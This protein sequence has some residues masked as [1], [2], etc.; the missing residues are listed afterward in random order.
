MLPALLAPLAISLIP[1]AA[2]AI[3]NLFA[4]PKGGEAAVALAEVAQRVTGTDDPDQQ[5]DVIEANPD[6]RLALQKGLEQIMADHALAMA[7]EDTER[8]RIAAA[9]TADARAMATANT[10]SG[11]GNRMRDTVAV[12]TLII[13]CL[14]AAGS[15]AAVM[16][17]AD[18][19]VLT[20]TGTIMGAT[21]AGYRDVV[22][23]F[24]GSSAGS[25]SKERALSGLAQHGPTA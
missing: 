20:L 8:A 5:R 7:R 21:I 15:V 10:A 23:Y 1:Q 3:G 2:S 13:F 12:A 24:L 14:S 22:G 11:A 9:N 25:A 18:P 4:G 16:M 17:N 6:A 19:V